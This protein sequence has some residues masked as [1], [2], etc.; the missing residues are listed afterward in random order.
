MIVKSDKRG[1]DMI[2][3]QN[4][5]FELVHDLKTALMKKRSKPAIQTY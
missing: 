2:L 4:A 5:E 3:I 1:E